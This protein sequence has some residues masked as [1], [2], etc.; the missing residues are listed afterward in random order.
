MPL[1]PSQPPRHWAHYNRLAVEL[2]AAPIQEIDVRSVGRSSTAS[3]INIIENADYTDIVISGGIEARIR[4]DYIRVG[5][6]RPYTV[7]LSGE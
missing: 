1:F 3:D 4:C 6:L 7:V 2:I 5:T